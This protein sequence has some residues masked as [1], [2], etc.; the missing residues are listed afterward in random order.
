M[1]WRTTRDA[2]VEDLFVFASVGRATN[3]IGYA[4]P[5]GGPRDFR[6]RLDDVRGARYVSIFV[7]G[8]SVS[9]LRRTRVRVRG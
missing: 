4:E 7:S 1:T 8:E 3:A 9:S 2:T 6:V 5:T